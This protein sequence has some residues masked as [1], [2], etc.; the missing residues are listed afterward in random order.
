MVQHR[1]SRQMSSCL[2][3]QLDDDDQSLTHRAGPQVTIHQHFAS[4]KQSLTILT[5]MDK[6]P[7]IHA[8]PPRHSSQRKRF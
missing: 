2:I 6:C 8:V 5:L 3:H 7:C 1:L 4:N